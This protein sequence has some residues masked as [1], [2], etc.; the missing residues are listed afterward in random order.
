MRSSMRI[1]MAVLALAALTGSAWA[2]DADETGGK[3]DGTYVGSVTASQRGCYGGVASMKLV[4]HQGHFTW[5]QQKVPATIPIMKNGEIDAK[6][7]YTALKGKVEG[8]VIDWTSI[9]GACFNR[10]HF[11]KQ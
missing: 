1:G 2:Q 5:V 4:V 10:A 7:A 9:S 6:A 8:N 11:E 3:Y